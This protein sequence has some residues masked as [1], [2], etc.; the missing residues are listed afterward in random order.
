[1]LYTIFEHDDPIDSHSPRETGIS[2][3]INTR[4]AQH[5]GVDHPCSQ[6]LNPAAL[7]AFGASAPGAE[8][9]ADIHLCTR[10]DKW[11]ESRPQPHLDVRMENAL[12]KNIE[13]ALEV[14]HGQA[15][16]DYYHVDLIEHWRVS[17]IIGVSAI[18]LAGADGPNWR[19]Q[20]LH[21]MHLDCGALCAQ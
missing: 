16:L 18:H 17:G 8:D 10:F 1:M 6:N 3:I 9:A 11:K 12:Q 14:T 13:H 15:F 4:H 7:F 19:T 5:I 21:G 20:R 2:R